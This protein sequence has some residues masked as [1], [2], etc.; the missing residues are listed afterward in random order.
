MA[1]PDLLGSVHDF[2]S[3][4]QQIGLGDVLGTGTKAI[5]EG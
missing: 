2:F 3:R 5:Q 4:A 1:T